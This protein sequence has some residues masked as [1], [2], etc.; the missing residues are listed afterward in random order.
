MARGR[1]KGTP[2]FV[3]RITAEEK[4]LILT[5][6]QGGVSQGVSVTEK[7]P[8]V[9]VT[10]KVPVSVTDIPRCKKCGFI[11]IEGR[12]SNKGCRTSKAS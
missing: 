7:T 3:M 11:L 2:M 12:C 6:R 10:P 1:P 8:G 5:K 9:S 4:A